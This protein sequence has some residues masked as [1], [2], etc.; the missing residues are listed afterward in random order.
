MVFSKLSKNLSAEPGG[1]RNLLLKSLIGV[2]GLMTLLLGACLFYIVQGN[3]GAKTRYSVNTFAPQGEVPQWIDFSITFSESIIDKSRVGTEVPAEALRFTPAVQGTARWVAF[4]Q[5]RFLFR[6]T[7]S[8]LPAQYTV[9]LTPELNPSEAFLLT[10]QKEFKFATEPFAVQQ[11]RMEFSTDDTREHATGLGT[12]AF[13]Y[14]VTTADLKAHL[15]IELDDGTEIP[16]QIETNTATAR[17]VKFETKRIKRGNADREIKVKIEKDFKC[18]G[19]QIGLEKANVTPVILRGKGTLGVTYSDVWESDGTPYISVSFSAPVLSDTIESYLELTPAVDYQVTSAYRNIEIHGDFKRRTTY[20]LKIRRGLTARND[21]VLKQDYMTRLKIP[22]LRP[23]LRFLGDGF[24]LARKGHLNLGLAT[25]NVKRV[26]LDIEKVFANNLIYVSRLDRW[27]RWSRNL[28][29][30][31]HSE[32]LDVPP[33]LNEEVTTP[34]SLENYLSDEHVGIFKVVARNADRQWN[35]VHQWLV[36]TDLGISAK[37]AGDNLYVWV[38]SLATGAPV[39]AARV[40][41]ISDNNQTLLS[42]TT[43][44]AGFVEVY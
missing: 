28:G 22:D 34:I 9:E 39:P 26:E 21:A 10:G 27:S 14:P 32:V 42:G 31:I 20:T 30:P 18:T 40:Q 6:C 23:Q 3:V 43:N 24:F 5:N 1:S 8:T 19:G 41:L 25:I 35:S 7:F 13:N 15:S 33:Q 11:T 29:K 12:I 2:I 17:T 38:K 36:I 4:E 44:W 16:Y 37:R